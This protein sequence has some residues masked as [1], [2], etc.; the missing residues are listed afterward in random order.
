MLTPC[1]NAFRS[2]RESTFGPRNPSMAG[3]RVSEVA[4][5]K[6]TAMAADAASP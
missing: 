4:M 3:R 1:A 6:A 5:V 2:R